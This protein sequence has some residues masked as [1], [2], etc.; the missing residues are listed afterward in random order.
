VKNESQCFSKK[1]TSFYSEF[2]ADSEYVS[3]FGK[4]WG[5]KNGLTAT[6]PLSKI[7]FADYLAWLDRAHRVVHKN[8]V[9]NIF[10]PV[11]V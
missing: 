5:R 6:C 11:F 10:R 1:N 9:F 3:L 4:C 7:F 2:N 8:V